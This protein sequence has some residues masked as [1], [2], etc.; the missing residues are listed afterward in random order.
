MRVLWIDDK[1]HDEHPL[2]DSAY[3]NGIEITG[4]TN[5]KGGMDYLENNPDQVDALI[6]DAVTYENE[7]DTVPSM[8]GL[9]T[10]YK[11]V[12]R[13]SAKNPIP[14]FI[15][16]GQK[17]IIEGEVDHL[18]I[19]TFDKKNPP[20][21]L[22]EAIEKAVNNQPENRIRIRYQPAFN[23]LNQKYLG[24]KS[25]RYLLDCLLQIE[26]LTFGLNQE[27]EDYLNR[28]RK[29]LEAL[30]KCLNNRKVLPDAFVKNDRVS[31]AY[32]NKFMSGELI[33][34]DG[35][36]YILKK[37]AHFPLAIANSINYIIQRTNFGSHH[38]EPHFDVEEAQRNEAALKEYNISPYL[39]HSLTFMVMDVLCWCE[40][41]IDRY[42]DTETNKSLTKSEPVKSLPH[43]VGP[44]E[45]K[46]RTFYVQDC[47]IL[48]KVITEHELKLG[49]VITVVKYT[50]NTNK[51]GFKYFCRILQK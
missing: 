18:D 15:Y 16:S 17:G 34:I 27:N 35:T 33:E 49:Q 30:F 6:L 46:E 31:L 24:R 29:T 21:L 12:T 5:V 8:K 20:E 2:L 14:C 40:H 10:A 4:Y 22:F 13:F 41:Y 38:N 43:I 26:E 37:E 51:N 47:W 50:E 7:T 19:P 39:L 9:Y 11:R 48:P 36:V 45:Q 32:S 23:V 44:L 42:P 3:V 25:E 1:Y 28:L